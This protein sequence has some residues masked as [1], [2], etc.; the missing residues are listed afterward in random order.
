MFPPIVR[1]PEPLRAQLL[2]DAGIDRE[3]SAAPIDQSAIEIHPV[4]LACVRATAKASAVALLR[5]GAVVI[6]ADQV[7]DIHRI[8]F[9]KPIDPADHRARLRSWRDEPI[10]CPPRSSSSDLES[11]RSRPLTPTSPSAPTSPDE[12]IHAYVASGD[13]SGC[14]GGYWAEGPGVQPIS[15]SKATGSTSSAC[16]SSA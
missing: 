7:A 5:P 10:A 2:R 8:A 4:S 14:A 15:K 11:T 3:N 13:G 6:G 9:G 12:E 1:E 16:R